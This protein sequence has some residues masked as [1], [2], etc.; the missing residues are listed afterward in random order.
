MTKD[1]LRIFSQDDKLSVIF[2][3]DYTKQILAV[4]ISLGKHNDDIRD[5]VLTSAANLLGT[6]TDAEQQLDVFTAVV[7]EL[8]KN[9]RKT[10]TKLS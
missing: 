4:L 10:D 2:D 6:D 8:I 7:K 9:N 3:K 1:A 5:L